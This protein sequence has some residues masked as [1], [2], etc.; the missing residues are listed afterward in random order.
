[1]AG[2]PVDT[3]S[4]SLAIASHLENMPIIESSIIIDASLTMIL[5]LA[6]K[7]DRKIGAIVPHVKAESDT[8]SSTNQTV[9]SLYKHFHH[10]KYKTFG[11]LLASFVL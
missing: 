8:P 10:Q 3:I 1:M 7:S 5:E 9:P 11:T 6:V 2:K 4:P